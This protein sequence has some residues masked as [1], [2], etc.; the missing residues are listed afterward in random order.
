M[1]ETGFMT[2]NEN[3]E[4][5]VVFWLKGFFVVGVNCVKDDSY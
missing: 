3:H 2:Y 1:P 4:R 5:E